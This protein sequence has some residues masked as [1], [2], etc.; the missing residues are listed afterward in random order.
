MTNLLIYQ[1]GIELNK[2]TMYEIHVDKKREHD[3]KS[4]LLVSL[5]IFIRSSNIL[6]RMKYP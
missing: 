6:G 3:I 1:F 2:L 5:T 4:F